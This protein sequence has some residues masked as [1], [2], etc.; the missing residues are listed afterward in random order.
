MDEESYLVFLSHKVEVKEQVQALKERL[1]FYGVEAFV[2]HSDIVP[3][4]EWQDRILAELEDM[5]AFVPILTEGFHDSQWTDQEVGF[6]IANEVPIV[7]LRIGLD[8]YGFMG[9]YQGL[10]CSWSDA[11]REIISALTHDSKLVD[12]FVDAVSDCPNFASANRLSEILPSIEELTD[13]QVSRLVSIFNKHEQ[14]RNSYGFNGTRPSEYGDGLP[15]FLSDLTGRDVPLR[16]IWED[17]YYILPPG[18]RGYGPF[19]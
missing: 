10:S 2:A 17:Q 13:A 9:K 3:G 14:I 4:T 19:S 16:E 15:G 6:A 8:P 7:P 5:N 11:P 18:P 12:V 1:E